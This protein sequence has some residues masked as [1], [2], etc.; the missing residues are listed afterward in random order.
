[1]RIILLLIAD[2]V[3]LMRQIRDTDNLE[4]Q[5]KVSVEAANLYAPLAHKLGLYKLKSELEGFESEVLG[6]R[7]ILFNQGKFE[8]HQAF[9]RCLYRTLTEPIRKMLDGAGLRYHMKGRTKSIHSIW[10]KMKKQQCGFNGVY[11]LFAIRIIL[12][13][14]EQKEKEQCWQVFSLITNKYESNLKACATG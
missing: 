13:V 2:S 4:A 7:R 6:T 5:H 1:M 9:A 3:C 10:Q 12:D 11:D 8:C 14:P